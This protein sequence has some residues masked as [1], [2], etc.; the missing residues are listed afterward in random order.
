[1]KKNKAKFDFGA[2]IGKHEEGEMSDQETIDFFQHLI[3]T[4]D[5]WKLQG[6][7]GCRAEQLINDGHCHLPVVAKKAG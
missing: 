1:M 4:G 7:Y 5:A 3:N 6:H 2:S